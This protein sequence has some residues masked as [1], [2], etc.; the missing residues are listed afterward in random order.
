MQG[1]SGLLLLLLLPPLPRSASI[2]ACVRVHRGK[3]QEHSQR[4]FLSVGVTPFKYTMSEIV[5]DGA[6]ADIPTKLRNI[7]ANRLLE[8][9]EKGGMGGEEA[10]T[11]AIKTERYASTPQSAPVFLPST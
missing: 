4:I 11:K 2:I 7:M 8:L 3:G 9:L 6:E 1:L 5:V 10:R